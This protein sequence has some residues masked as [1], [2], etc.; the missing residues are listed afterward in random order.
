MWAALAWYTTALPIATQ[1]PGYIL[2][3]NLKIESIL[4]SQVAGGSVK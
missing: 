3:D 1:F 2:M 4:D